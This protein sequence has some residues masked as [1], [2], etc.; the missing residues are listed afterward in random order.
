MNPPSPIPNLREKPPDPIFD[1]PIEAAGGRRSSSRLAIS[2]KSRKGK[3]AQSGGKSHQG[4]VKLN[5]GDFIPAELHDRGKFEVGINPPSREEESEDD[6]NEI[7][8]KFL[9]NGVVLAT[10]QQM[11]KDSGD[12]SPTSVTGN[13]S[14]PTSNDE[15]VMNTNVEV[16]L[17]PGSD[18][19]IPEITMLPVDL[20]PRFDELNSP[21]GNPSHF[22]G[23]NGNEVPVIPDQEKKR[24]EQEKE[25]SSLPSRRSV[26][27][28]SRPSSDNEGVAPEALVQS[29][30][31]LGD[32]Q[33][34]P[35]NAPQ[36]QLICVRIDRMRVPSLIDSSEAT[37]EF[38]HSGGMGW[39]PS[40]PSTED[41]H[42]T[43]MNKG[44]ENSSGLNS[45]SGSIEI[46]SVGKTDPAGKPGS[47][48]SLG[49]NSTGIQ[50]MH[51]NL[52][53]SFNDMDSINSATAGNGSAG[54]GKPGFSPTT[55]PSFR[56]V[57]TALDHPTTAIRVPVSFSDG[58]GFDP[59]QVPDGGVVHGEPRFEEPIITTGPLPLHDAEPMPPSDLIGVGARQESMHKSN[60][61]VGNR[62][63]FPFVVDEEHS[64]QLDTD[65]HAPPPPPLVVEPVVAEP[66]IMEP[67][68]ATKK[69]KEIMANGFIKVV[70][71]K[72]KYNG[73]KSRVQIPSLN[74]SKP[75]TSKPSARPTPN[76][77]A[78]TSTQRTNV[79]VSNAFSALDD[80]THTVD[81]GH[82]VNDTLKKCAKMEAMNPPSPIPNLRE[83]PPDPIFD[84]P[85]E[86]AGGR[87]SSSRLAISA[88]SR[89]GKDAQ[90][91]GK[92]H[93]GLVKLNL[94]DFIPAELHDR[95]KF[96]V[97][98]N[99]PSREEESEDDQ[100]EI[101]LK[102][103]DNGVVL[104]TSQQMEEDSGDV[105]PTSVTGNS[106]IPTSNDECVMNTNVEVP[107]SPGSD[108][109]IP[110]ITMLPV[111]LNPR[112]DELNSPKGNP[113]HFLGENGNEVPVIPDQEKKRIEQVENVWTRNQNGRPTFAEQMKAN[114]ESD[115]TRLEYFPPSLTPS[116]GKRVIISIEDLSFSAKA[117]S[118]H[119]YGYFLGN[120]P[121]HNGNLASGARVVGNEE[122]IATQENGNEGFTT[123]T[124]KRRRLK[125]K[126]QGKQIAHNRQNNLTKKIGQNGGISNQGNTPSTSSDPA[127]QRKMNDLHKQFID[128]SNRNPKTLKGVT[129]NRKPIPPEKGNKTQH[130]SYSHP[131]IPS[132]TPKFNPK[133]PHTAKQTK[134]SARKPIPPINLVSSPIRS[135]AS[136]VAPV[137]STANRFA[138]LDSVMTD[139][140]SGPHCN[141]S[142]NQTKFYE[143]TE[144]TIENVLKFKPSNLSIPRVNDSNLN[145]GESLGQDVPS[146]EDMPDFDITN[147]QKKAISSRLEKYGAVK[148]EDQVDWSQGEWEYFH[149]LRNSMQID[150]NT[151][152]ED[153]DS[154]NNGTARFF[155]YQLEKDILGDQ[156]KHA[157]SKPSS[158]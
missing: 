66:A 47:A 130:N 28:R 111:D 68:V 19:E 138:A 107:L 46:H 124:K 139:C 93:Q 77:V 3:D 67:P 58:F 136:A 9:D 61:L 40:N 37:S 102:F 152:V 131:H 15:C 73:P 100:N 31:G 65:A 149:Y 42:G 142:E 13:S 115:E 74:V 99:P 76:M 34:G 57:V 44:I 70:K 153:V 120:T 7:G 12:V 4:L 158:I 155:K 108:T 18:T 114:N 116:S 6:Q 86:A 80:I 110:E 98:I 156:Q 147:A 78:G 103:L 64:L 56:A 54:I 84:P 41:L 117:F 112:F 25:P 151:C 71:K 63:S 132:P 144:D 50:A 27:G 75:G 146:D 154:D 5:L 79:F 72:K 140:T 141:L 14:I 26:R 87:R 33:Q 122:Q 38:K 106:S 150:P 59:P 35:N 8:L 51:L 29:G 145:L 88:K 118:L 90:S 101:G 48:G 32:N 2:A 49:A 20:N 1:P 92:S 95:G 11:E 127:I 123:V 148:A 43:T 23:E 96:E 129:N 36:P 53:D 105:S 137:L 89:K 135:T 16:P 157:P 21:K 52:L 113:S 97:G 134:P 60:G 17:S 39:F 128:S 94:G 69:G 22:L 104:A 24:I 119:I 109:E 121:A 62:G 81:R 30:V 125:I 85:I 82:E 10:S 126:V 91:V 55:V 83:K 143:F 133:P 45:N